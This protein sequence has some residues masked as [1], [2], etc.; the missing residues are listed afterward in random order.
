VIL[1]HVLNDPGFFRGRK[2]IAK[3]KFVRRNPEDLAKA[4]NK[5]NANQFQSKE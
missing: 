1:I 5:T 3:R 4:A 2:R